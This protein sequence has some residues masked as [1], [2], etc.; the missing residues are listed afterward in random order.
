MA[1]YTIGIDFGTL[2]ARAVLIDVS[3]GKELSSATLD[4][5]HGVMD[6]VLLSSGKKL[7][8]AFALQ[9][10]N[11]YLFVLKSVVKSVINKSGI[12][13]D[14][15]CGLGVDFTSCTILPVKKDGTPLCNETEFRSNPHAYVK[16]WKHHAAQAYA[17]KMTDI[18]K[19]QNCEFL[20]HYGDVISSECAF[21]KIEQIICEAPEV[22]SATDM[23]LE[24]GDWINFMLTG[25]F[26]LSYVFAAYKW[27]YLDGKGFPNK[28]FFSAVD[29]RLNEVVEEKL[30]SR[31]VKMGDP[32]GTLSKEMAKELNLNESTV[33]SACVIDAHVAGAALGL[34][35]SG[36]MFGVI[37]TSACFMA[38]SD[39]ESVAPGTCGYAKDGIIPGLFGY[40]A[41]LCCMGDH[42][43]YAAKN[44]TSPEYAFIA[45]EREISMLDLLMEKAA[46]L[47]PGE[48]GLIALNWW[49]G[50][51]S[52]LVDSALSGTFIGMNLNTR[53]EHYMR[54][55][56]EATAF[57]T[58]NIIENYVNHGIKINKFIATGGI[59]KKNACLMQIFADVLKTDIY[60]ASVKEA[61]ALGA[62]IN[63][64]VASKVYA[65]FSD[66]QD[67][68]ASGY[69]TVYSPV[70]ENS[71]VYDK[72]F[73]EYLKLHDYF[74]RG[75]NDVMKNLKKIADKSK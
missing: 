12:S 64:A 4:Y 25:K 49:N 7:P 69:D 37:G 6:S 61:G 16:L 47:S 26:A 27:F 71:K 44:L 46:L 11:D 17:D 48:C 24:A 70:L 38:V 68:M 45:K 59:S 56:M 55:L 40:E 57:G 32:V 36:D 67:K 3:N 52:I 58:R 42:F 72:I 51:R 60:V 28:D 41:G 20:S 53:P 14:D 50:N 13:P 35:K 66:A 2:S 30:P 54:A 18:A 29:E 43:S 74:G 10:P 39:T 22:Y 23:F 31:I 34:K 75:G 63:A 62:A 21:P 15:V 5:P 65:N 1:K 33:V 8:S 73:V 19:E 9:D